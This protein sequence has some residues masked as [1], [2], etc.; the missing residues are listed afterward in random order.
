[1]HRLTANVLYVSN[2]LQNTKFPINE[3]VYVSPP[4]YYIDWFERY[5]LNVPLYQYDGTFFL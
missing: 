4:P 2:T 5:H 1:M 3:R